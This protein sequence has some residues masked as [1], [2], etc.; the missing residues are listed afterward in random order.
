MLSNTSIGSVVIGLLTL[1]LGVALVV[2]GSAA[3]MSFGFAGSYS[4]EEQ[5]G[6][7]GIFGSEEGQASFVHPIGVLGGL[8]A[9][10][11]VMLAGWGL[12]HT[13]RSFERG[14]DREVTLQLRNLDD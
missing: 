2:A 12:L 4:Y 3:V 5:H 9:V 1:I 13:G 6:P 7:W 8:M 10:V 14:K 11:G